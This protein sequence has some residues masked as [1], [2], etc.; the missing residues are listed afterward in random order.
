MTQKGITPG[1]I[2][3]IG[4]FGED[5]IVKAV[6]EL[7]FSS[8]GAQRILNSGDKFA[9]HIYSVARTFLPELANPSDEHEFDWQTLLDDCRQNRVDPDFTEA[10]F[11]LERIA[12]DEHKWEVYVYH[13]P[14]MVWG[15]DVLPQL[16]KLGYR[17]CGVRRAMQ[18][19]AE[20]RYLQ[21][22]ED[23]VVTGRWRARDG[24]WFPIFRLSLDHDR[25]LSVIKLGHGFNPSVFHPNENRGWLV[26]RLR[27]KPSKP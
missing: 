3:Q 17:P 2:R 23:L 14:K 4:R 5:A 10:N 26:Q 25:L 21:L 8:E 7:G 20:N 24:S 12:S 13:F 11:P 19:V 18:F 6:N 16:E 22:N 15:E 1:Q 9:E 27:R